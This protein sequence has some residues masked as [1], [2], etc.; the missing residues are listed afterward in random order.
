MF[1]APFKFSIAHKCY[2]ATQL[3]RSDVSVVTKEVNMSA[4]V[5]VECVLF[6]FVRRRHLCLCLLSCGVRT[7]DRDGREI[8]Q[9]CLIRVTVKKKKNTKKHKKKCKG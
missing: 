6:V 4:V 7:A 2:R 9:T 5:N 3:N 1:V 8:C